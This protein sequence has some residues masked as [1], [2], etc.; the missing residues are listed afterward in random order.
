MEDTPS[1]MYCN[2]YGDTIVIVME[3]TSKVVYSSCNGG[4]AEGMKA[5]VMKDTPKVGYS[6]CYGGH[7]ED[8]ERNGYEGHAEGGV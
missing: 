6:N 4:H 5:M 2:C 3:D 1:V 7:A 8:D